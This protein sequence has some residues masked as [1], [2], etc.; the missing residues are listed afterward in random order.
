[1]K[2]LNKLSIF[3]IILSLLVIPSMTLAW[4]TITFSQSNLNLNAGQ[5]TTV[6]VYPPSGQVANITNI[7]NSSVASATMLNNLLT[8]SGLTNGSSQITVCTFDS[9]C[10]T[11]SVAVNG[12][13]N[14]NNYNNGLTF[15]PSSVT[16]SQNQT[17]TVMIY[18]SNYYNNY[19][20]NNTYYVSNSSNPSIV[21]TNISGN[22]LTLYA[23]SLGS[24]TISVCQS[25]TSSQCGTVYVNVNGNNNYYNS[26]TLSP[27]SLNMYSGQTS[28]VYI[29]GGNSNY[30]TSSNY[31]NIATVTISGSTASVY[32]NTSG[33]TTVSICS[34]NSSQCASLYVTVNS[35]YTTGN[36]TFNPSSVNINQNQTATVTIN[37]PY[38]TNNSYYV[39]SNS[40]PSVV[41]ATVSGNILTVYGSNMGTSTISVCQ[42]NTSSQC[43]TVYVNVANGYNNYNNNYN[44]QLTFNPSS[45][46]MNVNQS[47]VVTVSNYTNYYSNSYYISNN[48]SPSVVSATV[49][50]NN[51]NL[52]GNSVGNSTITMCQTN[53]SQCG[54]V[55]VNVNSGSVLGTSI[56]NNGA[57][58]NDSGTIYII[59]KNT[60]SGFANMTTFS[61]LGF[62]LSNVM[63]GSTSSFVN[64]G[65]T[66]NSGT[67]A[68][69]WGSW[70]KNGN[71]IY[72]VHQSGLIPIGDYQTFLNNGGRDNLTV[73]ANLSD[74]SQPILSVMTSSDPRLGY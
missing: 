12:N 55:Y 37:T 52:Y 20:Y 5:S 44:N 30:Y 67:A 32:A 40:N 10:G 64:S 65:Y 53:T 60:K 46:S 17:S 73:P 51:L 22:N 72:F 21:S 28:T 70:I 26:I 57:L 62:K 43:G 66:V 6:T 47:S 58:I 63:N 27:S 36:I 3:A 48:S 19:N 7:T 4:G 13:N 24:T 14:Y 74:F 69:P 8:V 16:M 31:N 39:S 42:S 11:I 41:G 34:Y 38:F 18:G 9:S 33:S 56:Y 25:N 68:H 15:S 50:G 54:T 61:R 35:G 29:S 59:Y 1:M 45:V 23:N 2:N 49:S 71:T